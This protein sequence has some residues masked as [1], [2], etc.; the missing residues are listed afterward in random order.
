MLLSEHWT[1]ATQIVS[2]DLSVL[3]AYVL[4]DS[5]YVMESASQYV[6]AMNSGKH[7]WSMN[8]VYLETDIHL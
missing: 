4:Y 6:D 1:S 7:P 2:S 5:V 8:V 3:H